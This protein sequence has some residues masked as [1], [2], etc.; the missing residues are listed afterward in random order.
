MCVFFFS[1]ATWRSPVSGH[2]TKR[3]VFV[4]PLDACPFLSGQLTGK[5]AVIAGHAKPSLFTLY[6]LPLLLLLL[7]LLLAC[8]SERKVKKPNGTGESLP[9]G[10]FPR[11]E[12]N[13]PPNQSFFRKPGSPG[14]RFPIYMSSYTIDSMDFHACL[15]LFYFCLSKSAA[16]QPLFRYFFVVYSYLDVFLLLL[17]LSCF[18][19]QI[20]RRAKAGRWLKNVFAVDW[21][22]FAWLLVYFFYDYYYYYRYHCGCFVFVFPRRI[23]IE[24]ACDTLRFRFVRE[25]VQRKVP[26]VSW[27]LCPP[28]FIDPNCFGTGN[29]SSANVHQS[30]S[31]QSHVRSASFNTVSYGYAWDSRPVPSH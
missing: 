11:S 16:G 29:A 30:H 3:H 13:L 9:P 23:T 18:V 14:V 5:V 8:V 31:I 22:K 2:T 15:L 27:Q 26:L 28:P 21:S 6:F 20:K 4:P 24:P 12:S 17:L 10:R 7:L 1:W 25:G 19:R